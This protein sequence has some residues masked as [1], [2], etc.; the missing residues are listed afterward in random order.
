MGQFTP[1]SQTD[2]LQRMANRIVSRCDLNDLGDVGGMF[3]TVAAVA[4]AIERVQ[5]GMVDLLDD[6]DLDNATGNDLDEIG[7]IYKLTRE[8]ARYATSTVIYSRQGTTGVVALNI[9]EQVRAPE[10][11]AGEDLDFATTAA[12]TILAGNQD[13]A[14]IAI[15]AAGTGTKY[16]VD[17]G[18]ITEFVTKPSGVD[19]VSNPT[20]VTNG[21]DEETDDSYRER[22]RR[23][24]ASLSKSTVL[25]LEG[26]A[27]GAEDSVSGK[28]VS[29]VGV[30]QD[31]FW[32]TQPAPRPQVYVYI[33]D[34]AGTAESTTAQ[35]GATVLASAVGGEVDLYAPH[36]PIK[37]TAAYA[38][39]IN[40]LTIPTTDYY[41]TP[42]SGHFKLDPTVYTTGLTA[43][44]AVTADYTYYTGLVALVQ[45]I[46]DG[47]PADRA[48]YPGFVAAGVL[49][50]VL[51]PT[52]TSITVDANVTVKSGYSQTTVLA[53]V[54]AAIQT[55]INTLGIREDVIWTEVI[56]RIK[57]VAGVYDVNLF[58]NSTKANV[59]IGEGQVARTSSSLVTVN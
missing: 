17:P 45:K 31:E 12:G 6:T 49:C 41:F 21:A 20:A 25:G 59:I 56:N 14:P 52:I 22:I 36:K 34:G 23:R 5:Q 7:K 18:T 50:Q 47:D 35:T 48:N 32:Y 8:A 24:I 2:I 15:R 44:D 40:A 16:N 46:M 29:W 54:S 38:L 26:G 11:T 3:H 51:P 28:T 27:D 4:R 9:G 53:S 55:Y 42:T 43:L 30:Y 58:L 13:S 57:D 37:N 1:E 10:A 39:K 19:S 33:D